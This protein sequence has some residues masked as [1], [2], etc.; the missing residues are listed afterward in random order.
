MKFRAAYLPTL[1][2][3]LAA[4]NSGLSGNEKS[5]Y[6]AV[7]VLFLSP[8]FALFHIGSNLMAKS[9][10]RKTLKDAA[11]CLA[12]VFYFVAVILLNDLGIINASYFLG[13][14]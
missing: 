6:L 2:F 9:G 8:I 11:L 4:L 3:A 13:F 1:L 10:W 7:F 12:P 5:A 14:T